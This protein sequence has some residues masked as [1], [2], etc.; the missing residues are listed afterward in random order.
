MRAPSHCLL[1]NLSE[2]ADCSQRHLVEMLTI[3]RNVALRKTKEAISPSQLG[4]LKMA[5]Q[6]SLKSIPNNSLTSLSLTL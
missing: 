1:C 2:K 6:Y 5:T 4:T 3:A